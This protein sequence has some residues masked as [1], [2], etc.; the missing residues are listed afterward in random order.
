ML[1]LKTASMRIFNVAWKIV[2]KRDSNVS[3]KQ[4]SMMLG[5]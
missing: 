4:P 5:K 2:L 1:P 3:W